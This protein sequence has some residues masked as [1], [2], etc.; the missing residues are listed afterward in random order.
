MGWAYVGGIYDFK[1]NFDNFQINFN[2]KIHGVNLLAVFYIDEIEV[3]YSLAEGI[4][5]PQPCKMYNDKNDRV[6]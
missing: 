6:T 3:Y 2:V 4:I 5:I 1:I